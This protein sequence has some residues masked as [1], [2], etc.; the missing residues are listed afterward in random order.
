MFGLKGQVILQGCFYNGDTA[1]INPKWIGRDV[2]A[3]HYRQC[4]HGNWSPV[5]YCR[6]VEMVPIHDTPLTVS[7]YIVLIPVLGSQ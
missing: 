7:I 2:T 4:H 1:P 5:K 3:R 6:S